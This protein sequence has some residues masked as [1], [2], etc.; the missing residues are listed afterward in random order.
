MPLDYQFAYLAKLHDKTA[1]DCGNDDINAYL[2]QLA[3]QHTK[4][5]IARTHV[6]ADGATILGFYTLSNTLIDNQDGQIK[7]YPKQIPAVIIGRMG[8]DKRYQGQGIGKILLSHALAKT[9][10]LAK[11]T[12]I[13]FVIIDAKNAKLAS[14][15]QTFGFYSTTIPLRLILPTNQLIKLENLAGKH[16]T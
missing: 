6:L 7:G 12:G 5:G 14:Y 9:A 8:V 10:Q 16:E 2:K 11:D 4:K 3:N 15:Y 13:A 1:F